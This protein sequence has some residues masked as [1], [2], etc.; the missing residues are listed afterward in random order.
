MKKKGLLII[1]LFTLV[2]FITACTSEKKITKEMVDEQNNRITAE[3]IKKE[4]T[5]FKKQK[6]IDDCDISIKNKTVH[7][8]IK[9]SDSVEVSKAKLRCNGTLSE[10]FDDYELE[11]EIYNKKFHINGYWIEEYNMVAWND[12]YK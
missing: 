10:I 3:Q 12:E 5:F 4:E 7:V 8:K 1:I 11:Y 6:I 9:F 2:I